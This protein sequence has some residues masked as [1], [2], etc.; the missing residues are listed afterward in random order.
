MSHSSVDL[1]SLPRGSSVEEAK[2]GVYTRDVSTSL[3]IR[4]VRIETLSH[5][6]ALIVAITIRHKGCYDIRSLVAI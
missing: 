4:E 3:D 6:L 2:I 5:S 1:S